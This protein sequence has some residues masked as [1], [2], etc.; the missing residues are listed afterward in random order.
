MQLTAGFARTV[1]NFARVTRTVCVVKIDKFCVAPPLHPGCPGASLNRPH[2]VI[3]CTLHTHQDL[4][5]FASNLTTLDLCNMRLNKLTRGS[6][7]K[8]SRNG[9][10]MGK[11][12]KEL[13]RKATE[14]TGRR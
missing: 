5:H 14:P 10:R 4:P 6:D 7:V 8:D 2:R 1:L 12:V 11:R 13:L 3:T 9:A